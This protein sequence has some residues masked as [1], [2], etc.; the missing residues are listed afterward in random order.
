M[1]DSFASTQINKIND[2][3]SFLEVRKTKTYDDKK[4]NPISCQKFTNY[5]DSVLSQIILKEVKGS[6]EFK[7]DINFD[8]LGVLKNNFKTIDKQC[9]SD[10]NL[11][12]PNNVETLLDKPLI[13]GYFINSNFLLKL[14]PISFNFFDFII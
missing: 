9:S 8:T 13:Y 6:I 2:I 5:L 10:L 12:N 1:Y 4:N 3:I 11:L 7:Y 14:V